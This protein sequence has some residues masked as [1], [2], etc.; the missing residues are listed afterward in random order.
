M[1]SPVVMAKFHEGQCVLPASRV[2]QPF[3]GFL[4]VILQVLESR[5]GAVYLV[6]LVN[7]RE[8]LEIDRFEY[9]E[10]DVVLD[11]RFVELPWI[12]H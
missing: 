8:Q 3:S 12:L 9:A 6:S 7:V 11:P 1:D 2:S 4:F 10:N 5:K